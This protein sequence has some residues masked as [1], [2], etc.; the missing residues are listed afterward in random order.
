MRPVLRYPPV[1][2]NCPAGM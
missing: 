2:P 1:S